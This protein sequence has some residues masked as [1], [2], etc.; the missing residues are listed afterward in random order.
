MSSYYTY[1]PHEDESRLELTVK[2]E[3]ALLKVEVAIQNTAESRY[4]ALPQDGNIEEHA[5]KVAREIVI[6]IASI[7]RESEIPSTGYESLIES[8]VNRYRDNFRRSLVEF[9]LS[10]DEVNNGQLR[11]ITYMSTLYVEVLKGLD[12]VNEQ[13]RNHISHLSNICTEGIGRIYPKE[14]IDT[15]RLADTLMARYKDYV[16]A[17]DVPER[18]YK[19]QLIAF[20]GYLRYQRQLCNE[21]IRSNESNR[22]YGSFDMKIRN[23]TQSMLDRLKRVEGYINDF[24]KT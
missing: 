10:G 19:H 1:D 8:Y 2:Q 5:K 13:L 15:D 18:K 9:F 11:K 4:A 7:V 6:G 16:A 23:T 20:L 3:A 12:A 21:V 22:A 17:H 24:F 14:G